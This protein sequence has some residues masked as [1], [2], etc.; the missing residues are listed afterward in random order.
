LVYKNQTI[1]DLNSKKKKQKL[2]ILDA[3]FEISN[4]VEDITSDSD[5]MFNDL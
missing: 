2:E 5:D 1:Y 3:V 4:E